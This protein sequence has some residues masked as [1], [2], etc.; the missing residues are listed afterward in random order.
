MPDAA[1]RLAV[2]TTANYEQP[3]DDSLIDFQR[4]RDSCTL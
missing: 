4:T 2:N 1:E 3:K